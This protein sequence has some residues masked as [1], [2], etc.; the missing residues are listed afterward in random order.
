MSDSWST[1]VAVVVAWFKLPEVV[2]ALRLAGFVPLLAGCE[3]SAPMPLS[4]PG[5]LLNSPLPSFRR[6]ALQGERAVQHARQQP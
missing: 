4:A 6:S 5:A 3:S 1:I 2:F